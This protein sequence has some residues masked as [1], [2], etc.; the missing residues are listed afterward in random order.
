MHMFDNYEDGRKNMCNAIYFALQPRTEGGKEEE[1]SKGLSRPPALEPMPRKLLCLTISG[2]HGLFSSLLAG[3]LMS[4]F[5][6]L[7][8]TNIVTD[9]S[10][11]TNGRE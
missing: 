10:S 2:H 9:R 5:T 1:E 7:T 4:M 11:V 6:G 8:S 3:F